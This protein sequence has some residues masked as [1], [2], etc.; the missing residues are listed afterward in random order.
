MLYVLL[1]LA[2]VLPTISPSPSPIAHGP[3]ISEIGG[4][5]YKLLQQAGITA[6]VS[7]VT[8]MVARAKYK[9]EVK[10]N[11]S[12]SDKSDSESI[13]NYIQ[14][15]S[16]LQEEIEG[17]IDKVKDLKINSIAIEE[18]KKEFTSTVTRIKLEHDDYVK[19]IIRTAKA[20]RE[21]TYDMV[22][23]LYKLMLVVE[24]KLSE[25]PDM[26]DIKREVIRVTEMLNTVKNKVDP[27]DT[28]RVLGLEIH[29]TT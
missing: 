13:K 17:W 18:L 29:K 25:Y 3:T 19:G 8:Y 24:E 12:D 26:K 28:K 15:I 5:L 22:S 10:K 2:E 27:A 21:N 16:E 1:L 4:E 11:V 23:R 7:F 20:D 6:I 9:S 14:T